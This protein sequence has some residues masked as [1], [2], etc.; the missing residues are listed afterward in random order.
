MSLNRASGAHQ[1]MWEDLLGWPGPTEGRGEEKT[2]EWKLV[3]PPRSTQM[4]LAVGVASIC[5]CDRG[6]EAGVQSCGT[7]VG[8]FQTLMLIPG[9]RQCAQLHPRCLCGLT[10]PAMG[11]APPQVP[12]WTQRACNGHA[13]PQMSVWTHCT[14]NGHSSTPGACVDSAHL[15]WAQLRPRRLCGLT[16]PLLITG[17]GA[18]GFHFTPKTAYG[19]EVHRA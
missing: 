5:R 15:Q 12:A 10:A 14:Y 18:R 1:G 13:P 9:S 3:E 7:A 16:T 2:G 4:G 17:L 6:H 19:T 11:T 8:A